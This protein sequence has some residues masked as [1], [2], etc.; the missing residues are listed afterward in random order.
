MCIANP[1]VLRTNL[2]PA[3]PFSA[4]ST[5]EQAF[6]YAFPIA[7]MMRLRWSFLEDPANPRSS[8]MVATSWTTGGGSS[9]L[10][11]MT[12]FIRELF[13]ISRQGPFESTCPTRTDDTTLREPP[14][15][16]LI[17]TNDH[18]L[19]SPVHVCLNGLKPI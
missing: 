18:C 12:R 4:G 11:T 16:N 9:R 6:T 1:G 17:L 19:K 7:E 5:I 13:S 10:Q 8:C 14:C 15:A 2:Q 3:T